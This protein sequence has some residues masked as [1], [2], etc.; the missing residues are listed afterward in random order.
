MKSR[1]YLSE[2]VPNRDRRFGAALEY[3][4]VTIVTGT[5]RQ[6]ALLTGNAISEGLSRYLEN[7]E[8]VAPPTRW[9]RAMASIRR[10]LFG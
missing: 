3:Y 5:R 10:W 1:I 6:V 8:D 9:S 4:P 2:K 7:R